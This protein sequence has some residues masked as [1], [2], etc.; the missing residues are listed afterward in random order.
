ML[1]VLVSLSL[2]VPKTP[3]VTE[4]RGTGRNVERII[5]APTK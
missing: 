1:S 3:P 2:T 4:H 5:Y